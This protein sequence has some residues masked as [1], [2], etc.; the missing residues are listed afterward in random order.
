MEDQDQ[1]SDERLDTKLKMLKQI[2]E[3]L[4]KKGK[5]L[6]SD[7]F[8]QFLSWVIVFAG[9]ALISCVVWNRFVVEFAAPW[10]ELPHITALQMM[11]FKWL[12]NYFS[13]FHK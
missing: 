13:P 3:D 1:L 9:F 5:K 10:V 2:R 8:T 11:C 6:P 4:E 12:I 7:Y